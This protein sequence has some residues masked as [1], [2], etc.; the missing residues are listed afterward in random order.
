MASSRMRGQIGR[1]AGLASSAGA[2]RFSPR[3][4]I[5]MAMSV[6]RCDRGDA[7]ARCGCGAEL[8]ALRARLEVL[9]ASV[10]N[11]VFEL[12][13]WRADP[14]RH[15]VASEQDD[16]DAVLG[17]LVAALVGDYCFSARDLMARGAKHAEL[18]HALTCAGANR[19]WVAAADGS[20][21][22]LVNV[23][24]ELQ[25]KDVVG[26]PS[27]APRNG[28][29][30]TVDMDVGTPRRLTSQP[31]NEAAPT[32][33]DDGQWVYFS[34]DS[35]GERNVWRVRPRGDTA[36]QITHSGSGYVAREWPTRKAVLYQANYSDS[37]LLALPL[38]GGA[39][40]RQVIPCVKATAFVVGAQGLVYVPC[41]AGPDT[42]VH[43]LDDSTGRDRALGTLPQFDTSLVIPPLV[44][45]PKGESL[46]YVR[47]ISDAADLML[48]ENFR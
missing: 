43:L 42:E 9:T 28:D 17:A 8:A 40:P 24:A 21:A 37:P 39:A 23:P 19:L 45:F 20:K 34:T 26:S 10:A 44:V 16:R 38:T 15:R 4:S 30:W 14:A 25:E 18:R 1:R 35:D 33:S 27:W 47:H 12:R 6:S 48:I 11:L 3:M 31:G 22:Q 13:G 29:I 41:G 36:Q 5:D 46:L 7:G 32:W 2:R